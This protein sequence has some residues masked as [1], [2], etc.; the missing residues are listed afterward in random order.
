MTFRPIAAHV[1]ALAL[2]GC[3]PSG[4][5]AWRS[6][7]GNALTG[8]G[9]CPLSDVSAGQLV[10][11]E[12]LVD[13]NGTDNPQ[14]WFE[15][16][17]LHPEE[18]DLDGLV[19]TDTV[20]GNTVTVSGTVLVPAGGTV[21]LAENTNT[22]ANGGLTA[23][24][25]YGNLTLPLFNE[26]FTLVLSFGGTVFDTV[27]VV[28]EPYSAVVDT[29]PLAEGY[30]MALQP[31]A[32]DATS[33][34]D[35]ANW[36]VGTGTTYGSGGIG[37]P[38]APNPACIDTA[39]DL[40]PGSLVLTEILVNPSAIGDGDGEWFEFRVDHGSPI[41][42]EGL[43]V[44]GFV[45]GTAV[46]ESFV[47]TEHL[48][49]QPGDHV[50]FAVEDDPAQNGNVDAQW[51]WSGFN[52]WNEGDTLT[53]ATPGGTTIDTVSW[54]GGPDFPD[55]SGAALVLEP[56]LPYNG[57]TGNDDGSSWCA[58]SIAWPGSAGD[59]GSPGQPNQSCLDRDM[60]GQQAEQFGG[61]DCDDD[62]PA[63]F[64]SDPNDPVVVQANEIE[65]N[66]V[67]DNC[68]GLDAW[69][70]PASLA[71][72]DIVITEIHKE[73]V[74][75]GSVGE[76]FE[77]QNV[78]SDRVDLIGL[79]V[80]GD[81]A[82]TFVL[83]GF[84]VLDP[85][86]IAVLARDDDPVD[87]GGVNAQYDWPSGWG[88]SNGDDTIT[89]SFGGITVDT[90]SYDNDDYPDVPG[91]TLSLEPTKVATSDNDSPDDWC[92]GYTPFGDGDL[93]SPGVTNP[94]CIGRDVDGDGSIDADWGGD[95]CDDRDPTINPGASE[96]PDD[97]IDQDCDGSDSIVPLADFQPGD[98]VITEIMADPN[99]V[100]GSDG[101][102]FEIHNASVHDVDLNGLLLK[103][104][105]FDLGNQQVV[106]VDEIVYLEAGGYALFVTKSDPL[107]NGDLPFT[108]T[109]PSTSDPS[110]TAPNDYHFEFVSFTLFNRPNTLSIHRADD[111]LLDEV[112]YDNGFP[113]NNGS[114]I[115]L[116]PGTLD[117]TA[118]DSAGNWCIGRD[119][120]GTTIGNF[121]TPG[122][123]NVPCTWWMQ[124]T[125]DYDYTGSN[126]NLGD[127][128]G[129][130]T[131][132]LAQDGSF[133]TGN[134]GTGTGDD[135]STTTGQEISWTYDTTGVVYTGDRAF[136]DAC[137][138]GTITAPDYDATWTGCE[139]AAPPPGP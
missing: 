86:E 101:E 36:C 51:D 24:Y 81:A 103:N 60:D 22:L 39:A 72:G 83:E 68:D 120:I 40:T 5:P 115:Q 20:T 119:V 104:N 50:V 135:T 111:T 117:A 107:V 88:L 82:D 8:A 138:G 70:G 43:I 97:R 29:W 4:D 62:D 132:T 77:I 14:E 45:E 123:A 130:T 114:S 57:A 53:L 13:P 6:S 87:N 23:D 128:T 35:P 131:I 27:A 52:L 139:I 126:P 37:T 56:T 109:R 92:D 61:L 121:G 58:A 75:V 41:D 76:W 78:S 17:N 64:W 84:F 31:G 125:F 116:D 3:A 33:N 113:V 21:V 110:P 73:P 9:P 134:A 122:T 94:V 10:V 38:G 133:E 89:L 95:D 49:H 2:L 108:Y 80:A 18:V 34:D 118:N 12:I 1:A 32:Q 79:E 66:G 96:I 54:D 65:D 124:F 85:G 71:A 46:T 69:L 30:A 136:G 129:T 137:Y 28:E 63:V 106:A 127:F 98:L 74:A 91:A 16:L 11:T 59:L 93:G 15:V 99:G 90:V 55:P 44:S 112:V 47:I 19:L 26:G 102:W 25:A 7:D 105:A 48:I 42:L 67:D 100:A